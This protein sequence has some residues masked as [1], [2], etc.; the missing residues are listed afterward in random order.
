[1]PKELGP[2]A[3]VT[4]LEA[5]LKLDLP[6]WAKSLIR[7]AKKRPNRLFSRT[8]IT[9]LANHFDAVQWLRLALVR[10]RAKIDLRST[11][12]SPAGDTWQFKHYQF[13]LLSQ[14]SED[15]QDCNPQA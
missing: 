1:M 10:Q 7:R 14:A 15:S 8:E 12:R 4:D 11:Q 9:N 3:T 5:A 2:P 13:R 6:T